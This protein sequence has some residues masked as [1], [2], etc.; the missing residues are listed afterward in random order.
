MGEDQGR[1]WLGWAWC[2]MQCFPG[3]VGV[4]KAQEVAGSF[5]EGVRGKQSVERRG[6]GGRVGKGGD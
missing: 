4:F 2:L 6:R 1:A 5:C 3:R